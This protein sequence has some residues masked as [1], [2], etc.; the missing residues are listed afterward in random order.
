MI[1]VL[2]WEEAAIQPRSS[3]SERPSQTTQ[4]V[5]LRTLRPDPIPLEVPAMVTLGQ[6]PG[7]H[8]LQRFQFYPETVVIAIVSPVV[9]MN[10]SLEMIPS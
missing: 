4:Q 9:R 6:Y 5:I 3:V 10:L 7:F 1:I 8:L 2:L